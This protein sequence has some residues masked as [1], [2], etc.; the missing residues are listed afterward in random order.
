MVLQH[1]RE[2][3]L[4]V[5]VTR[6]GWGD[7]W[8]F[9]T[10]AEADLHP[11]IQYGDAILTGPEDITR[12][13]NL[14]EIGRLLATLGSDDLRVEVLSRMHPDLDL[15]NRERVAIVEA[16]SE[17]IWGLIVGRASPPPNDA[18]AIVA[19]IRADRV[20]MIKENTVTDTTKTA[21]VPAKD[22]AAKPAAAP[23]APKY[24]PTAKIVM[25]AD[26]EGKKYGKDHNPKRTGSKA[27]AAFAKLTDGMTVEA[28]VKA[29]DSQSVAFT[30]I[31][32]G[33]KKGFFKIA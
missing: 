6:G 12:Q 16:S 22:K 15:P 1:S 24:A 9:D 17:R 30:E 27:H 7:F 4:V 3:V 33:V 31:D 10:A 29:L 11:L 18:D 14:L 28:Y 19:Q 13:Y 32:Y 20:L 5:A 23:R 25:L 26:K 21:A 8:L 2:I